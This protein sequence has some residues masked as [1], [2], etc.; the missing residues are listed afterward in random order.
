MYQH[1]HFP[2]Q[3][4]YNDYPQDQQKLYGSIVPQVD[5]QRDQYLKFQMVEEKLQHA[6][7]I[8]IRQQISS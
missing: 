1:L 8:Y 5:Q 6:S 2:P 7:I 3:W 4:Q